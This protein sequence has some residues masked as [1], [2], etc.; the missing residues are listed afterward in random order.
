MVPCAIVQP[1]KDKHFLFFLF[2]FRKSGGKNTSTE[3][4][5]VTVIYTFIAAPVS[6]IVIAIIMYKCL[7]RRQ[8]NN[9]TEISNYSPLEG[10]RSDTRQFKQL[11]GSVKKKY[12]ILQIKNLL[13]N[14]NKMVFTSHSD[15][16]K[17]ILILY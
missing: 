4:S 8:G 11:L 3:D 5:H 6:V 13:T 17:I 15:C 9:H 10:G 12:F 7:R 2:F 14:K 16:G 1:L